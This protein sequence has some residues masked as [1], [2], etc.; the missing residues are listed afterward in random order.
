[1]ELGQMVAHIALFKGLPREQL[2]EVVN[3]MA[4]QIFDRGQ[5]VLSEGEAAEGF[6][7]LVQGRVKIFKISAE[8]K[9]Q[10]LHFVNPG[11]SFGEVPMFAGDRFP[12]NAEAIEKSRIFFFPR[13]AFLAQIKTDPSLAMNMLAELS[14]RL[15]QM[16]RLVEELSLKEVPG[17]LAAYILYLSGG[18]QSNNV[19]LDITKG[20][21]ASL[22]GTIPET[23]SRILGKMSAQ[24]VISVQGR[25]LKILDR[26][27][28][29]DLAAGGKFII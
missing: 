3:S 22:L 23:L 9:E 8:G 5:T 10:I 13:T 29:E 11:E 4:D 21:L 2:N 14:R 12:A 25:K 26:T 19:E 7:V 1:M 20:Q 27:A 15:R 24:E 6:F 16:T 17:R 28:L 18:S